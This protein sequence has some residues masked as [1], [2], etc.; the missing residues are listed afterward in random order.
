VRIENAFTVD[1]PADQVWAVLTDVP[2]VVSCMPG[3]ELTETIDASHWRTKLTV[4]VGPVTL[5]FAS[6]L[7]REVADQAAGRIVM[8]SK[9]RELRGKGGATATVETLVAAADC[10]THVAI[11]TDVTVTGTAA[12][13]GRP[14]MQQVSQKLVAAFAQELRAQL[15]PA[16]PSTGSRPAPEQERRAADSAHSVSARTVLGALFSPLTRRFHRRPTTHDG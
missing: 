8:T 6:D 9:A 3:A 1:A 4:K 2:T 15:E 10:G 7:A 11:V 14:V 5:Q 13:F 16:A 12:Q